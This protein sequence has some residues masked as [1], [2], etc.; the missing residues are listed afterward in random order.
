M[1]VCGVRLSVPT[2]TLVMQFMFAIMFNAS[3]DC[4]DVGW[5]PKTR[6]HERECVNN[7]ADV[8]IYEPVRIEFDE[9][10]HLSSG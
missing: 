1:C 7:S 10:Y 8:C 3:N 2:A 6:L 9:N 5:P 4:R